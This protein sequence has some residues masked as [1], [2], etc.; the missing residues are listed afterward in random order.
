M[1]K[2]FQAIVFLFFLASA[3]LSDCGPG[4]LACKQNNCLICNSTRHYYYDRQ[5]RS[6]I[7]H[8]LEN[9]RIHMDYTCLEC[10]NGFALVRDKDS[11]E[12]TCKAVPAPINNCATYQ[13]FKTCRRCRNGYYLYDSGKRCAKYKQ[14]I[15]NCTNHYL[16]PQNVVKCELCN[17]GYILEGDQ[18]ACKPF[19]RDTNCLISSNFF[20]NKC[21]TGFKLRNPRN[22]D[23]PGGP[24][25]Y[26]WTT[27]IIMALE[28]PFKQTSLNQCV[29]EIENCANFDV[30]Y[31]DQQKENVTCRE[32]FAGY[33]L[34]KLEGGM[35]GC[36]KTEEVVN[37]EIYEDKETCKYCKTGFFLSENTCQKAEKHIQYCKYYSNEVEC[38]VCM[39]DF[40]KYNESIDSDIRE[41]TKQLNEL[42]ELLRTKIDA[43]D[44][45]GK[46]VQMTHC[47][48][49]EAH[50]K[51]RA[52]HAKLQQIFSEQVQALT[53]EVGEV[54]TACLAFLA[55]TSLGTR[56][57]KEGYFLS[58]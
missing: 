38:E 12:I 14:I 58:R 24:G 50:K 44:E 49:V 23:M 53:S 27:N 42:F 57:P 6:C 19:E 15:E 35:S 13:N 36:E 21:N 43:D 22:N 48:H 39:S 47:E 10:D 11:N 3:V 51:D 32:C 52:I 34:V 25:I 28:Q 54:P 16:T 30:I 33:Y 8:P 29:A 9:C 7:Y 17:S 41:K 31:D 4:C 26:H 18:S 56:L 37:C 2:Y 5:S 40:R 1:K 20:C 46:G 45:E 55:A